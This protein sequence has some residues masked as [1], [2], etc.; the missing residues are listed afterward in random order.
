M[1]L[2]KRLN[3]LGNFIPELRSGEWSD[4]GG[5]PHMEDTHVCIGNLAKTFGYDKLNQEVVSL[6]GVSP[7]TCLLATV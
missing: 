4:I 1:A 7:L 2:E 6:Y 3:I 5:R